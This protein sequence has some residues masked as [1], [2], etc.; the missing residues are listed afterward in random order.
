V[1]EIEYRFLGWLD[2]SPSLW[3]SYRHRSTNPPT[4]ETGVE[5]LAHFFKVMWGCAILLEMNAS[6][7]V[8]FV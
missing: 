4:W 8:T 6:F 5:V 7:L 3:P 2:H 1:P